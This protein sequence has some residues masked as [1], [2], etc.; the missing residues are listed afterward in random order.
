MIRGRRSAL[1]E[2]AT[3]VRWVWR[4]RGFC[5]EPSTGAGAQ[6]R[7]AVPACDV[8]YSAQAIR[9]VTRS[10]ETHRAER[11]PLL[12]RDARANS[13]SRRVRSIDGNSPA[14]WHLL[15]SGT[16]SRSSRS[17]RSRTR[18]PH[19]GSQRPTSSAPEGAASQPFDAPEDS[20]QRIGTSAIPPVSRWRTRTKRPDR[21][22]SPAE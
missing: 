21:S 22:R 16:W 2:S 17:R 20:N 3:N 11:R 4:H 12:L 7:P 14:R 6:L 18:S 13:A 8:T 1:R 9:L 15:R 5:R 19:C 10:T